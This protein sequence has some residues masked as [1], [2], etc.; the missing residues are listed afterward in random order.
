MTNNHKFFFPAFKDPSGTNKDIHFWTYGKRLNSSSWQW[1]S[2]PA[3]VILFKDPPSTDLTLD[4]IA[5]KN[6]YY[7]SHLFEASQATNAVPLCETKS[8]AKVNYL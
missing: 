1:G 4:R 6:P 2:G 7:G 5:M 3:S 8:G